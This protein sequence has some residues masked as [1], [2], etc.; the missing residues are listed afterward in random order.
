MQRVTYKM[1][2][3]RRQ[4]KT[5]VN[6]IQQALSTYTSSFSLHSTLNRNVFIQDIYAKGIWYLSS[7]R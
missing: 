7:F 1:L 6:T 5:K 2:T 4:A 3:K